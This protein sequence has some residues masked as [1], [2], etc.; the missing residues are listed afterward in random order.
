MLQANDI[1]IWMFLRW[2][3][4]LLAV[5]DTDKVFAIVNII[6]NIADVYPQSIMYAYKLSKENYVFHDDDIGNA[7]MQLVKRCAAI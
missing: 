4:Q 2:I 1:P 3:P 6:K 7:G 5:V